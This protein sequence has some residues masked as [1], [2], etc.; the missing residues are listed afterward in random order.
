MQHASN[1]TD[2]TNLPPQPM[3][4]PVPENT[5]HTQQSP[6]SYAES[7]SSQQ[8]PRSP[9]THSVRGRTTRSLSNTRGKPRDS[10]N[11]RHS[12]TTS[13]TKLGSQKLPA[14]SIGRNRSPRREQ[15]PATNQR[16]GQQGQ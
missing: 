14:N 10:A 13:L 15:R 9:N 1:I 12:V 4:S 3:P 8:N 5:Q 7:M 11:N 2:N 6:K 16:P